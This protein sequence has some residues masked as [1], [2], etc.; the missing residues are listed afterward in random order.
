MDKTDID[1]SARYYCMVK[2]ITNKMLLPYGWGQDIN[3]KQIYMMDG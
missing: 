2:G 1:Y 3:T